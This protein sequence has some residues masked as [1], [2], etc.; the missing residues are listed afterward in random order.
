[1]I[2]IINVEFK[3]FSTL[4]FVFP[5]NGFNFTVQTFAKTAKNG[6]FKHSQHSF[7]T[8]R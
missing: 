1:M 7:L 5:K 4:C 2:P 3:Q 8:S 6:N